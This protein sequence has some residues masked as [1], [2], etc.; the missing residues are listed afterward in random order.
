MTVDGEKK[1]GIS[2]DGESPGPDSDRFPLIQAPSSLW[3]EANQA[4]ESLLV[5]ED[6]AVIGRLALNPVTV[7]PWVA[8]REAKRILGEE[9]PLNALVVAE[10]DRPVGLVMSI[11]LD[12]TLSRQYGIALYY[13]EP[14]RQVMDGRPLILEADTPLEEAARMAMSRPAVHIYDHIIITENDRLAGIV[15]MWQV[16]NALALM[17]QRRTEEMNRINAR[18]QEEISE[19]IK[20]EQ[21]LAA[22]AAELSRSNADLQQFAYFASHDLQEPLRAISG[23][24]QLLSQRYQDKLDDRGRDYIGRAVGAAGRMRSLINDLL[25]YS[26]VETKGG[27]FEIANLEDA[28][29]GALENLQAALAETEAVVSRD[30]LPRAKVD[31]IQMTQL[32]QN[33]IGNAIKFHRR[34]PIRIRVGC[35]TEDGVHHLWVSDNGIGFDARQA[36]RIFLIFQRL[37][38]RNQYSGSGIGLSICKRIVERH[39]GRIWAESEEGRGATFHFTLPKE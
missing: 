20:A 24:L 13:D 12:R 6:Q 17:Q 30:P 35:R 3:L 18:L 9:Q 19:K 31:L 5:G 37:H 32:F 28:L 8:A 21:D 22:R 11:H 29:D 14:V 33:L 7:S 10:D 27:D 4:L 16:I 1:G 25:V 2:G 15:S 36:E 34:Q 23:F 26:R 38:T 39:G